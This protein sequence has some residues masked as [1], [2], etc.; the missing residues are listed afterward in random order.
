MI[1]IVN[2]EQMRAIER[3][4]DA[5]GVSYAQ[6]MQHAGRAVAEVVKGIL[7][8][9]TAGKRVAVLVG[10]GNNGGD[11]L[12]AA[13]ILKEETEA[14]VGCYL[15]KPRSSDDEVFTAARDVGVFIAVADDDQRWRVLKNLISTA[16][17]LIDALLGTGARLPIEGDLEKLLKQTA[18]VLQR[19]SSGRGKDRPDLTW[20]AAPLPPESRRPIVVAVDCPS[21]LDCDTGALDPVAIPADMT[22]TFAAAKYGQLAFPG[23]G[24][25]GELVVAGIGTPSD[26]P[27]LNAVNVE[28]VDGPSAAALLPARPRDGHKG[29]FGR[30]VIVAGSI[31]YTGAATLAGEAAYRVGAGLVTMAVPQA[32]YPVLAAHLQETTWL[33]LPHDMGVIN[34]AALEVLHE[35]LGS[36]EAMLIGPGL[37]REEATLEFIRGLFQGARQAKKGAIGFLSSSHVAVEE[38]EES[39]GYPAPLIVDADGLNLLAEVE[40]WW[41][42]VPRN[43]ILTPHPGEMARLAG[44]DRDAIQA[45]RVG[46]AVQKAAEWGCVVVLKGAFTVIA[47]PEGRVAV[48]P[49]ATDALAKAGTGDV[50]A[51]CIT[52]LVAQGVAPFDA[53]VAGAYLHG[54]AGRLAGMEMPSRSV[55]AGDVLDKLAEAL[56]LLTTGQ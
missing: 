2:V 46:V 9:D 54:L 44:L 12:V 16:D 25:V 34:A 15:L 8:E 48:M 55:V 52:G 18:A 36:A 3:A 1:K 56:D 17:I 42:Y 24:A 4:T 21:G 33:L 7:G 49:F 51:G 47:E 28:L 35:E 45:D 38:S 10:P 53:A 30:A 6:M 13:R 22:V 11:G 31:N 19:D 43:T 23:A 41:R 20:P 37:G 39:F 14:E 50:L 27:E 29:T 5:A 40:H 32:I 26:L